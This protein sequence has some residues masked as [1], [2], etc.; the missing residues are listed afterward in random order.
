[1]RDCRKCRDWRGCQEEGPFAYG[2]IKF[3]RLQMV[4]LIRHLEEMREG[5]WPESVRASDLPWV[6]K[7]L[8]NEAYFTKAA[9]IAGE[10]AWRLSKTNTDGKLLVSQVQG[11]QTELAY[12]ARRALAFISGWRRRRENYRNWCRKREF[13]ARDAPE[14]GA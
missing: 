7:P 14:K 12:E 5:Q 8:N 1:M 4:W 2:D 6:D 3:C 9:E 10:V 11:G 13:V